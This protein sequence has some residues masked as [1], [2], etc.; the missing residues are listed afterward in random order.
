MD[1]VTHKKRPIGWGASGHQQTE[2]ISSMW[3]GH[4]FA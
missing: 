2:S 1:N 4:F 3:M